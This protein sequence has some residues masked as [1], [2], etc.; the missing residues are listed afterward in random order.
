[1][2][3]KICIACSAGG[4][5]AET[6]RLLEVF[7]KY[8]LFYITFFMKEITDNLPARTYHVINPDIKNPELGLK[9]FIINLFQTFKI[10]FKERPDVIISSGATVAFTVCYIAKFLFGSKVL[11]IETG[12][13]IIE[14]SLSGRLIYPIADMFIVQWKSMLKFYPKA[15]YGGRLM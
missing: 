4:H 1:M 9:A 8:D 5:M 13:R 14:P 12:S 3:I 15:I 7:S 11:F 6:N 10:L 2:V